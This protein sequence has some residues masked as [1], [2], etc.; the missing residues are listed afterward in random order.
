MFIFDDQKQNYEGFE[1]VKHNK[2]PLWT[3]H[4]QKENKEPT[5]VSLEDAMEHK[6]LKNKAYAFTLNLA[7]MLFKNLG[8][9]ESKI[10]L[11][12]HH[13]DEKAFYADDAWDIELELNSFGWTEVC[14][15]HDRTDYD[16]KKHTEFSKKELVARNEANEKK[17]PHVLEIAFG[18]DR[19]T[20][21]LLD[22]FFKQDKEKQ[23]DT[24][25]IPAHIAPVKVAVLSL[26]KKDGIA[27][28]AEDIFN[29]LKIE[30]EAT[31]DHSGSIGRRYARNDEIGTPFCI[32]VDYDTKTDGTVTIR[33][34][35]SCAQKRI[36]SKD[37]RETITKLISGK[38][39]FEQI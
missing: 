7:Y 25:T 5:I 31:I 13:D 32:T 16:L 23:Q 34:R 15:V 3:S 19:P 2:L 35:D 29:G 22:M 1:R 10:R 14:G 18:T 37:C 26:V 27:E 6:F 20:F 38:I 30:F 39:K 4:L 12:Q 17:V 36:Q 24:L 9:P 28:I 33:E 8:I 11:R 21:A